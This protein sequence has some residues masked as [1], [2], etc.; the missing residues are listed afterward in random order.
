[1]K[2]LL[3]FIPIYLLFSS[4]LYAQVDAIRPSNGF[5]GQTLNTNITITSAMMT[6]ASP[7]YYNTDVYLQNGASILNCDNFSLYGGFPFTPDSLLATFTL[8]QSLPPGP[9]DVHVTTYNF[10]Q[11][12]GSVISVDNVLTNGFIINGSAGIIEGDV[13]YDANQNGSRDVGEWGLYGKTILLQPQNYTGLT[14]H[15]GHYKLYVDT[16]SYTLT[17]LPGANFSITSL[18]TSYS[19]SAPPSSSGNDFGLYAPPP[20]GNETQNFSV[21][22]HPMRC[23]YTG[24][25]SFSL[26]NNSLNSAGQFGS[27]T[28]EHS[29]NLT[30]YQSGVSPTYISGNILHWD[31]SGLLPG[32]QFS[33]SVMYNNPPAGDTV[34]YIVTDSVFDVTFSVLQQ[35]YVDSFGTVTSCSVDPNDKHVFPEGEFADHYTLMN[36]AL[37]YTI[38]FQNTGTDTAF[39]VI[40]YD[41]L[42]TD[43]DPASIEILASSHPVDF[44]MDMNGAMKFTF[45]HIML[46]DSSIDLPGSN[47]FVTYRINPHIGLADPTLIENTA[48]IVFDI[49]DPVV[50]NTAFNTMVNQIPL[51]ITSLP[52]HIK[53][54][55]V[56]NPVSNRSELRFG[57][58]GK[59][60][61]YE[62][63]DSTGKKLLSGETMQSSMII[64]KN[65]FSTG[66]YYYR[67]TIAGGEPVD[68]GKFI[69]R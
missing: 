51:G 52:D 23:V 47:G 61:H 6:S 38:D 13:Y 58:Q 48:Y 14:D 59:N 33:S 31:Y 67:I 3:L 42:D 8:N 18:P 11:W 34:W 32:D 50:T 26:T 30:F 19:V 53:A 49:N 44:Q 5:R 7:P 2:K 22:T 24:F 20:A 43:L 28:V 9:Y 65:L 1:M 60:I 68:A 36:S 29:P 27:V 69:V 4:D 37:T 56:P 16:G 25:S 21:W 15:L 17:V 39:I 64:D 35:V 57:I 66:L 45:D 12:T 41:T 10:D 62:I 40:I 63:F 55:V 46:P 54:K